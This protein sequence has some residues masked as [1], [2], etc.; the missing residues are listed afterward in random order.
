METFMRRAILLTGFNNWGKTTQIKRLFNPTRQFRKRKTY[1]I[2]GVNAE[3]TVV[4][5]SNDDWGRDVYLNA[6]REYTDASPDKGQDLL[7][8]FCP[9]REGNNDSRFILHQPPLVNYNE[10]YLFYLHFKWDYHAELIIKNIQ[11]Y[12][13]GIDRLNHIVIDEENQIRGG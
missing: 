6:L 1:R 8:A 10:I 12:F 4:P 3:F 2:Q 9:T 7:A 11:N 5:Y 13:Q